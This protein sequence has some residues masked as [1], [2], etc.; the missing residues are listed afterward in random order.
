MSPVVL[1]GAFA[2]AFAL[3]LLCL[4]GVVFARRSARD[5]QLMRRLRRV[6]APLAG[7][8]EA[9][10]APG[11]ESVFRTREKDARFLWL[12]RPI[13]RRYPLVHPQR[14]LFVAG[15][16][17]LAGAGFAAFALWFLQVP[18]G[19]WTSAL[20]SGAGAFGAWS[21]L[22]WQQ[23]RCEAQFIRLFPDIVDQIV[24]LAGAG[25]PSVEALTVVAD[26]TPAPVGPVLQEV[27]DAL[28]AGLDADR[29]LRITSERLRLAEFTLF[30]AV[31]RLQRRSGG[32][33]SVAFANLSATLRERNKMVLTAHASTAQTRLT[34]LVLTVMPVFVLVAQKFT[35]PE[36]VET[37]FGTEQGVMLLRVGTGLIVAGLLVAR[38]IAAR[39]VR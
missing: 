7:P 28:N 8:T 6:A 36:S 25:V 1:A 10:Q 9:T 14:A 27:C 5:R 23:A 24:R 18:A 33:I 38:F 20:V 3:V 16:A 13:E 37:L 34:L 32:R 12:W 11:A 2:G 21:A 35:T 17:G 19:W 4:G 29:A 39:G 26:D 31:L 30:C 15:L 22:R